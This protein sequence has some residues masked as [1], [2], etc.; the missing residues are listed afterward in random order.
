MAYGATPPKLYPNGA[1]ITQCAPLV[2][3]IELLKIDGRQ[4][5]DASIEN[6]P[7]VYSLPKAFGSEFGAHVG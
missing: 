4:E 7:P 3:D 5:E 6:N 2:F 1:K